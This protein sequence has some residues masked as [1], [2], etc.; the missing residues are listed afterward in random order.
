MK[1][2]VKWY[3]IVAVVAVLTGV[4]VYLYSTHEAAPTVRTKYIAY[5][6]RFTNAEGQCS[7]CPA[8]EEQ[9]RRYAR[10][11]PAR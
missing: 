4:A 2:K 7:D 1:A 8:G 11:H 9:I 5:I 10:D 3:A 6:G